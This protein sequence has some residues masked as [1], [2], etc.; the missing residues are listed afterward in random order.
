MSV[1][2]AGNFDQ[3]CEYSDICHKTEPDD[4]EM[5]II[6]NVTQI[7]IHPAYRKK[8]SQYYTITTEYL[9]SKLAFNYC[10][11]RVEII[12]FATINQEARKVTPVVLPTS[13]IPFSIGLDGE[14]TNNAAK[15]HIAGWGNDGSKLQ[16]LS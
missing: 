9:Q 15:C 6:R 16:G 13:H 10:L 4:K 11:L 2:V 1:Q 14:N 12:D 3:S 8:F 5:G 7:V